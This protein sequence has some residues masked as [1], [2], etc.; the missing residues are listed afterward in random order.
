MFRYSVLTLLVV[1][2]LV[3]LFC[4]ALA[5]PS[6][7]LARAIFGLTSIF[8]FYWTL[9]AVLS[10]SRK[11]F[12]V[13]FAVVGWAYFVF[14]FSFLLFL[15]RD[16]LLLTEWV[17]DEI[18]IARY[19]ELG[20]VEALE[21]IVVS[22]SSDEDSPEDIRRSFRHIGHCLFTLILATVGGLTATWLAKRES[23]PPPTLKTNLDQN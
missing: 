15:Q 6:C 20:K 21:S 18:V 7:F 4:A 13:G 14:A 17:L 3:A 9:A 11:P 1:V 16:E 10:R 23:R 2:M 8:L 22:V 5:K 12:A 19:G